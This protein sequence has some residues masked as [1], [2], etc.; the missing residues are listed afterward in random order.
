MRT[1][2]PSRPEPPVRLTLCREIKQPE[3]GGTVQPR[4]AG[5]SARAS[6]ASRS[7]PLIHVYHPPFPMPYPDPR[8]RGLDASVNTPHA[9]GPFQTRRAR[10]NPHVR[11]NTRG[12]RCPTHRVPLTLAAFARACEPAHAH[13]RPYPRTCALPRLPPRLRP[14]DSPGALPRYRRRRPRRLPPPQPPAVVPRLVPGRVHGV[15]MM[16]S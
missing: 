8:P 14:A 6:C 2:G 3:P 15:I 4:R 5:E 1:A 12:T 9:S 10:V 7:P 13:C 11:V 16:E